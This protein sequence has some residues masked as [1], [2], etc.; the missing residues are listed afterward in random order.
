MIPANPKDLEYSEQIIIQRGIKSGGEFFDEVDIREDDF[1]TNQAVW[2]YRAIRKLQ[3]T[4]ELVDA[5]TLSM[6]D[7]RIKVYVWEIDGH[8]TVGADFHAQLV[9]EDGIRR[10][11]ATVGSAIPDMTKTMEVNELIE[12]VR[13]HVD[14]AAGL[15]RGS[16]AYVGDMLPEVI[17]SIGQ[18]RTVY[19][20]PWEGVNN[21][22]G[23][24]LRPGALYV[25]AARPSIGKSAL[26][27]QMASAM[28]HH[29]V[30]SFSSLEMPKDELVLRLISQGSG[31][32][33]QVLER[34]TPLPEFAK[35]KIGMW[36]DNAPVTIAIDDRSAVS[37]ADIRAHARTVSRDGK[38]AGIVVDYLQL[39]KGR[40]GVSRVEQVGEFT[41]Q[42]KIMARDLECP[43]IAL[44]Q[45]NRKSE[46][47]ADRRPMISDLRESG[48][49]EQDADCVM[50][51]FRD[52]DWV[53]DELGLTA[54]PLELIIA[55]N[56][57]GPAGSEHLRWDGAFMR[58]DQ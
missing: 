31:V 43:V 28:S 22:L 38:L 2:T 21:A 33:H 34:G 23:G 36:R 37:V 16:T 48:S 25:L 47:R 1:Q 5:F 15:Q 10:R 56:R 7:E 8:P 3:G 46:D 19:E 42:L 26:A 50:L 57:H 4:G 41:R 54:V 32:A 39:L 9:H 18:P 35:G 52:P 11:L 17:E 55:K 27:L 24:G 53:P 29:G 6:M 44:S 45:L 14:D 58:A 49:I 30:V 20:T 13:K 12:S 51:M 40:E